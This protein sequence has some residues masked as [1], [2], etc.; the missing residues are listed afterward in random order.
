MEKVREVQPRKTTLSNIALYKCMMLFCVI[1]GHCCIIFT[2]K[3]W[4]GVQAD[5]LPYLGA[6]T[7][8]LGTFHTYAFVF[9][10]G[11]LFS[12]GRY[13]QGKYRSVSKDVW[14]RI[15]RLLIPYAVIALLW[16]GPT[17][18]LLLGRGVVETV[19]N[20]ALVLSAAQLWF[21]VMLFNVWLL[22]YCTSDW[23]MKLP[24]WLGMVGFVG[25]R[26]LCV[27]LEKRGLPIG[28]FGISNAMRYALLF[29][30]GMLTERKSLCSINRNKRLWYA[31]A[32]LL[33]EAV[34]YGAYQYYTAV[35]AC[36]AYFKELL[37]TAAN[38]NG[39]FLSWFFI[40]CLPCERL[41]GRKWFTNI[42]QCSMGVYLLHQQLLYMSMRLLNV[43]WLHPVV[44]VMLNCILAVGIPTV[45]VC[46]IRK[47]K[48]GRLAIG[49]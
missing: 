18:I 6:V 25:L 4:G 16:A 17:D 37:F 7:D 47:T 33:M 9:A 36:N 49:G 13:A 1:L 41:S 11:Y 28:A 46:F 15:Q 23:L 42:S 19:K 45:M 39:V 2:G 20:Y 21:L 48:L 12:Y 10:S 44:F 34:V 14:Q 8:W 26:L 3:N 22:F 32:L 38:V 35:P 31:G 40:N 27:G 30:L 24:A 43:T 29:Y 5:S